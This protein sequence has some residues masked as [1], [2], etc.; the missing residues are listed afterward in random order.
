MPTIHLAS[1]LREKGLLHTSSPQNDVKVSLWELTEL[2]NPPLKQGG[3]RHLSLPLPQRM[4]H[5][6]DKLSLAVLTHRNDD[7]PNYDEHPLHSHYKIID[8]WLA[9]GIQ[10]DGFDQIIKYETFLR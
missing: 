1:M 3:L 4:N 8:S 5:H 6:H 2:Y 7:L 10:G 9:A